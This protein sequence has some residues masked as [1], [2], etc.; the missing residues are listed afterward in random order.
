MTMNLGWSLPMLVSLLLSP[1]SSP[2]ARADSLPPLQVS[3]VAGEY[4]ITQMPM[5]KSPGCPL[6]GAFQLLPNGTVK[7]MFVTDMARSKAIAF[8]GTFAVSNGKDITF[9]STTS[10][11]PLANINGTIARAVVV[12][13]MSPPV[14]RFVITT[15]TAACPGQQY[16]LTLASFDAG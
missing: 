4:I 14:E 1:W 16:K 12:D 13:K 2:A 15:T 8:S 5:D 11:V 3:N 6:V 10:A 7:G 9:T